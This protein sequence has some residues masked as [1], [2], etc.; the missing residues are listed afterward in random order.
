MPPLL[1]AEFPLTLLAGMAR[2]VRR[3]P[4]PPGAS[5]SWNAAEACSGTFAGR[6]AARLRSP[7]D[8]PAATAV[9]DYQV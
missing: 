3:S 1:F 8:L 9:C 7:A 2:C 6:R 4:F 5:R